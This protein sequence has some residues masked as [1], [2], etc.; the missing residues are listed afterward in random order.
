MTSKYLDERHSNKLERQSG[1]LE[2]HGDKETAGDPNAMGPAMCTPYVAVSPRFDDAEQEL[3]GMGQIGGS[4]ND[5][6]PY[7]GGKVLGRV[8]DRS[9]RFPGYPRSVPSLSPEVETHVQEAE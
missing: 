2:N 1:E 3:D 8:A 4:A 7:A 6:Y 9:T 5:G